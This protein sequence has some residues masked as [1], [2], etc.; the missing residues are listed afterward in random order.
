MNL[1]LGHDELRLCRFR[2]DGSEFTVL[3]ESVYGSGHPSF[4]RN[5]R[6]IIADSYPEEA[7]AARSGEV[8]VR[9]IDLEEQ[10]EKDICFIFTG[11]RPNA[12]V[13]RIDPHVVWSR[14]YTKVC[15]NGASEGRRQ[16]YIADLSELL[17]T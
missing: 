1:T 3:S 14:D 2:P 11:G 5:G 6:Y 10:T 4:H 16:L 12:S 8:P 17:E 9:L 15:F 13:L 7:F